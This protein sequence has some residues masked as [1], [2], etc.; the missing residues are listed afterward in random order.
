MIRNRDRSD[1]LLALAI[2]VFGIAVAA[3]GIELSVGSIRRMGPGFL[4][5]CLGILMAALGTVVLFEPQ[6]A[7]EDG[8]P[9]WRSLCLV[10]LALAAF[11]GLVETL[12]LFPA[13][14]ALVI[15]TAFADREPLRPLTLLATVAG[16][17]AVGYLLFVLA[18]RLPFQPFNPGLFG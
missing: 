9:G 12:G 11:A 5:L 4:P 13:T 15:L 10:S 3:G 6:P 7:R 16:L 18:L 1:V 17:C 2:V 8:P 14:A